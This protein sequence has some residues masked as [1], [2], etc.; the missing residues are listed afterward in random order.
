MRFASGLFAVALT[1][2][3]CIGFAAHADDVAHASDATTSSNTASDQMNALLK[4]SIFIAESKAYGHAVFDALAA[5]QDPHDWMLAS[6][7][8]WYGPASAERTTALNL[9]KRAAEALPDDANAQWLAM[10]ECNLAKQPAE[11]DS[12]TTTLER[13]EPDNSAVWLKALNHAAVERDAV[14]VD[15]ALE[16]MASGT[17]FDDHL[18]GLQKPMTTAFQRFTAPPE[19]AVKLLRINPEFSANKLMRSIAITAT[20]AV[21]LPAYQ[22]LVRA[23]TI[24]PERGLHVERATNCAKIGRLLS[25]QG[26][27]LVSN[28]IGY[29][30]LRVSHTWN[31]ADVQA[32]RELDWLRTGAPKADGTGSDVLGIRHWEDWMTA[33]TES[34]ALRVAMTRAGMPTTPP[35]NWVDARS[36]FSDE[37]LAEDRRY[38]ADRAKNPF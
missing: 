18:V 26:S 33:G 32:A 36:P 1:G 31:D 6:I 20:M 23:C 9:L 37:R 7:L 16:H 2:F 24:D 12:T 25:L 28:E 14:G 38:A 5:S 29:A 15:V 4:D 3:V 35:A 10:Q 27:D 34:G 8:H 11:C 30:I 21:A 22:H 19:L 13:I 17:R